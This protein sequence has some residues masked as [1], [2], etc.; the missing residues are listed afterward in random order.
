MGGAAAK[1]DLIAF[2]TGVE[3]IR[4]AQES[5]SSHNGVAG[6][7]SSRHGMA[8]GED[9]PAATLGTA[10]PR[11]ND[12]PAPDGAG[13]HRLAPVGNGPESILPGP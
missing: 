8:S 9:A 4:H 2:T 12:A 10:F 1:R 7:G 6:Q 13:R 11:V 3:G 5:F